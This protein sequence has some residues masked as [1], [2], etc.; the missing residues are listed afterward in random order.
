M[1]SLTV[2]RRRFIQTAGAASRVS[3]HLSEGVFRG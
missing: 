3:A 1:T 2:S